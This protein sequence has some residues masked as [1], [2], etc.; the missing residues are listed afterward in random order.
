MGVFIFSKKL[1]ERLSFSSLLDFAGAFP[2]AQG[3][4]MCTFVI[5][6]MQNAEECKWAVF[7]RDLPLFQVGEGRASSS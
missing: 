5:K 7:V 3:F 6:T 2:V 4:Q 1:E